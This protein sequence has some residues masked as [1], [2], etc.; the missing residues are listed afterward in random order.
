MRRRGRLPHPITLILLS[1]LILV[2]I[3]PTL[4]NGVQAWKQDVRFS[5]SPGGAGN[6]FPAKATSSGCTGAS[7]TQA[8]GSPVALGNVDPISTVMADFNL[9]GK[10]DLA[11]ANINPG[12]VTILFGNGGGGFTDPGGP[13]IWVSG[14]PYQLAAGD[15]NR[16]GK[17]DL[18]VVG[19][20]SGN[21]T[22]LLGDGA[23]G[24][25][26][27]PGSPFDAAGYPH[28][29]AVGDFNLDGKQD[30]VLGNYSVNGLSL[31][32][33]DGNGGFTADGSA[34]A[35]R[36]RLQPLVPSGIAA[37]VVGDFN[38][39]GKPDFAAAN[40][41]NNSVFILLGDGIGGFTTPAGSPIEVGIHPSY[42]TSG[43]FNRDGKPDLAVTNLGA[44]NVTVLLGDGSGG[45]NQPASSP[46]SVGNIPVGIAAG[47]FN[48]DGEPD[49]AVTNASDGN[50]TILLG[51]GDGGFTAAAGSPVSAG[52]QP[53][54]VAAGDFN[55]DGKTDLAIANDASHNVT[56]QLNTCNY[57]P[58]S[59][60]SFIL[61]APTFS[62][63]N[64]PNGVATGD[65]NNDG[66]PDFAVA[67]QG[68]NDVTV[69]LGNGTGGFTLAGSFAALTGAFS[70]AVGDVNKDGKQ[71]IVVANAFAAVNKVSVL[72]GLGNG[73]FAPANNISVGSAPF[74]A[75]IGDFN[76]D[77]NPDIAAAN[78]TSANVSI[79]LGNGAGAFAPAVNYM[80]GTQPNGL[81][82]G[83]FNNDGKLDIVTG[84][85]D[86]NII[87]ILS[88]N[89]IGGFAPAASIDVGRHSAKFAV[90][91]FNS[92]GKQD[93]AFST[94]SSDNV[95]VLLGDGL[96]GFSLSGTFAGSL[97]NGVAVGDFNGD[98]KQDIAY[99]N[100]GSAN[101]S[102]LLGNGSGGFAGP[103]NF[104]VGDFPT[105]VATADFDGDGR[106]DIVSVNA[107]ASD[108]AAV[109][110]NS[111]IPSIPP[112][113]TCP[114]NISRDADAGICSTA[115]TFAA[116]TTG[117]PAPTIT[118]TPA[119]GSTFTKGT[120]TVNCTAANGVAPNASC[121]FTV[122]VNDT[123][124][125]S[126]SCPAPITKS[127][128]SN[129]CTAVVTF[130]PTATD[131]C[132][133]GPTPIACS[134]ASGS[135]FS[136]GVTTVACTATD[137]SNNT[138]QCSFTVTV[139]DTQAPAITCPAPIIQ[140]THPAICAAQVSYSATATDACDGPRPVMCSPSS[141]S[142]FT[143]GVTT[144][145]CN[146]SD[147][148]GNSS[149]CMFTVTVNDATGPS[150]S[151]ADT[152]GITSWWPATG[153]AND[154]VGGH[155]GTLS[156]A[157][158]FASPPFGFAGQA[159]AFDGFSGKDDI[160]AGALP[161]VPSSG[162]FSVE[163]W[164]SP[165]NAS[166]VGTHTVFQRERSYIL[167][168]EGN[169]GSCV[170]GT[171]L[172]TSTA[173]S[174]NTWTHVALTYNN[175]QLKMYVNGSLKL[176]T[177]ATIEDQAA[178]KTGIG[179]NS[180]DNNEFFGGL[181][182][183]VAFYDHALTASEVAGI[184]QAN[185]SG[186]CGV[187]ANTNLGQCSTSVTFIRPFATDNCDGSRPV[188]CAP[189]TGSTFQKGVT[190]VTCASS[191][192]SNNTSTT[193]F[194]VIVIDNEAP[195][196]SYLPV[197]HGTDP[198]A[199]A[200]VVTFAPLQL[201]DNCP[202]VDSPV[203]SP[204][205][206][207]TFPKGVTTVTCTVID[208][209]HN[210]AQTSFTVTVNDTQAPTI[211]CPAPIT[212]PATTG[213]CSAVAAY[214]NATAT[215]NCPGVGTPSCLPASGSTFQKGVTTVNCTVTDSSNS[216]STCGFTV[217]V[218]DTQPPLFPN[219]CPAG[220]TRSA[221]S[222]CPITTSL[223]VSYT[224]PIATDNCVPAPSVVCNPP[225]GSI[226]PMGT[227]TVTCTATDSSGNT[228]TCTFPVNVYNFCIKDDRNDGNV[229]FVNT[230]TGAY[231]FCQN[232]VPLASGTGTV[233]THGCIFEI[234]HTKGDRK[235]H[236]Q[237]DTSFN[238]NMGTGSAYVKKTNGG[239]VV[240]IS[241]L[242]LS[243]NSCTCA[244]A[245]PLPAPSK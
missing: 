18:A 103:F 197:S 46:V 32:L 187:T 85:A 241:D 154:I 50:V 229:V 240:E 193:S 13:P 147:T 168:S 62:A 208:A 164:M 48:F 12:N 106:Q 150:F 115:V 152:A 223:L 51:E 189:D 215:D 73:A 194:M 9:D 79:L 24:F 171:C 1:E 110:L 70:V 23:G 45:F 105:W 139:N 4:L 224:G 55:L 30:L 186:K 102:V 90:D 169:L 129:A 122:T 119:S 140:N 68:T 179:Y 82:I 173:P 206:G 60:A 64:N 104:G 47:D 3:L 61:P 167:L 109:L 161:N 56:I 239:F 210:Q 86:T 235:V 83:D 234:D 107:A 76:G 212:L 141:G 211:T 153:N 22:I 95:G 148:V 63:G 66:K 39:D 101:V 74:Q 175:S 220:I 216:M 178:F 243:N 35:Q 33:G 183:E 159:F 58:C 196:I 17:P 165:K 124:P 149:S 213:Q 184:Y 114:N 93:I 116:T 209:S 133:L 91:D 232:G 94:F 97:S 156:G 155:N 205:S 7:F 53:L 31:L 89:G 195:R 5:T 80:V 230:V 218:T 181:V 172:V 19:S 49:L 15:F 227:T 37:I 146:A 138:A 244:P 162:Q 2:F 100:S 8:V 130:A 16:D 123:Q 203:C 96:G 65:F 198:N 75:V 132:P 166:L 69:Y 121:M 88:G 180:R 214:A 204:A 131:N 190:T 25:T 34:F 207:T 233:L 78:N 14:V 200:A 170:G 191:D 145:T 10:P 134:P 29:I 176:D 199:C 71:D 192:S 41:T 231:L 72:L 27:P 111:C 182:D 44:N 77:G 142:S 20:T 38:R 92:D 237:G 40:Q 36:G 108:Y 226:F 225:S 128:D 163:L 135:T 113:I 188:T 160:P 117:S 112:A 201:S 158:S 87:S 238:E 242:I 81:A 84:S 127:T 236:I 222:S 185:S 143:K 177:T 42:I 59:S 120:T 217:T 43:D 157:V 137:T 202:G 52:A 26:Q 219:G 221:Q 54:S 174:A 57:R 118:C 28:S 151:C 125:P 99:A 11:T 21:V 245:P 67:S 136:K 228:A 144:V 6:P 98:G 126:I